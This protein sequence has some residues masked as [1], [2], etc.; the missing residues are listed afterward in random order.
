MKYGPV[1]RTTLGYGLLMNNYA[2]DDLGP[3]LPSN[4]QM[5]IKAYYNSHSF[6][7]VGLAT[8]S[9]LYGFRFTQQFDSRYILGQTYVYDGNG[10]T[11]I[12]VGT[13]M[14]NYTQ[15][16]GLSF[17][18]T[19]P[20]DRIILG[21]KPSIYSEVAFLSGRGSGLSL[22][23]FNEYDLLN[24]GTTYF[25]AERIFTTGNFVPR[26]FNE[27]YE[28]NPMDLANSPIANKSKDGYLLQVKTVLFDAFRLKTTYEDYEESNPLLSM[29]LD[30][31]SSRQGF[32]TLAYYQ[33]NFQGVR[34]MPVNSG[35][36]VMAK[37][38]HQIEPTLNIEIEY[39][40]V[41]DPFE[42]RVYDSKVFLVQKIF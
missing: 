18:L 21:G 5:G 16:S 14:V 23:F 6:A 33:V 17:D 13:A 12:K 1:E 19:V 35:G 34:T 11:D 10:L 7:F 25:R 9:S 36:V 38:S 41:S 31:P 15:E 28:V 8:A 26:Y 40:Q 2:S 4:R 27:Q 42:A 24:L 39:K 20:V 3:M 32:A 37:F 30:F 22:G 29:Q